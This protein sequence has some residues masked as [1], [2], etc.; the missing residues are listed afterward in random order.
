MIYGT[1][2]SKTLSLCLMRSSVRKV[3][4]VNDRRHLSVPRKPP[5]GLCVFIV[6]YWSQLLLKTPTLQ[7]P[8]HSVAIKQHRAE[9]GCE[10]QTYSVF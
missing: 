6:C 5:D 7:D 8:H 1:E 3:V 9:A 4:K 2:F 10:A